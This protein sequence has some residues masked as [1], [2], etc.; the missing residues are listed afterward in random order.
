MYHGSCKRFE[1]ARPSLTTRI[2]VSKTGKE[3]VLYSGMS[4]H[5]TP[6]KWIALS[7]V[8]PK[9]ASFISK[10][11]K[12]YYTSGV[13]LYESDEKKK[14][15]TVYGKRD[16]K[17]TLNKLYGRGGYLYTLDRKNFK[18]HRGL[19]DRELLSF[20]EQTPKKIT[21]VANP[22]RAMKKLGVKF[23]FVDITQ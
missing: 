2:G 9:R 22:V 15:V 18:H 20:S 11:V 8:K 16:L 21:R 1:T 10:G 6:H 7:Y 19:G 23:V 3:T 14:I 13:S 17:Y 12:K 4:L 5:A